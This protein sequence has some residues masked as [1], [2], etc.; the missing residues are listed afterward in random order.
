MS[1]NR[2]TESSFDLFLDA[3]CNA[4][5]GI[6]FLAI[7]LAIMIQNRAVVTTETPSDQESSPDAV[8]ALITR[9]DQLSAQKDSLET[10]L[11]NYPEV[12]PGNDDDAEYVDLME[13]AK[14]LDS[15]VRDLVSKSTLSSRELAELLEQNAAQKTAN[16]SVPEKLAKASDENQKQKAEYQRMLA[17]KQKTLRLPK[18]RQSSSSRYLML[19]KDNAIYLA[20]RADAVGKEFESSY[21]TS[22]SS[23]NGGIVLTAIKGSGWPIGA[24]DPPTEFVAIID[25]A[26]ARG[27]AITFAVWPDTYERFSTIREFMI[28]QGVQLD[29]WPQP[30]NPE[31]TIYF[32]GGVG[33]VQ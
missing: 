18:V 32:G 4:F 30:D 14:K 16:E 1:R 17:S 7:L 23:G 20:R 15:E 12:Q 2:E 31:L 19:A 8:R 10:L 29:L 11:A 25:E 21:V 5:G 24:T 13:Q 33:T 26:R 27:N 9:L 28:A 22:R 3:V 6:V